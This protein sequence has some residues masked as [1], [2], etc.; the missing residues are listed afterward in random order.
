MDPIQAAIEA[1]ESQEPGENLSIQEV[2]DDHGVWRSTMQ[3]RK[4][5][6]IVPRAE[7]PINTQKLS[8]QQED[9]LVLCIEDHTACFLPPTRAMI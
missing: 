8:P 7:H 4:A 3:R 2:A 5:G 1:Y 6:Q 9:E